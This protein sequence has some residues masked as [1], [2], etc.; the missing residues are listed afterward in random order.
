[1]RLSKIKLAGFKSFVD[2]TTV[3]FPSNLVGVVGPNGCGKSN[4]IDAVRWVMGESSAKHLRG[5][6]M[7]DVIF[8]GSTAR[9][10]VGQASVELIFDNADGTLSGEYAHYNEISTKR[11]VNRDGASVYYLNG[12]RCRRRDITDIFLGTGLGPRSYAIIEQGMISRLIEA[13]PEDMRV[14]LEEAA[15]ISRYKERRRETENRIRHTRDNL[16]RLNDLRE[17]VDKHLEHLARQKRT[18]ERY[19]EFKTAERKAHAELLA[20]RWR[21]MAAEHDERQRALAARQTRLEEVVAEQRKAESDLETGREEHHTATEAFNEVQGRYYRVGAEISATEQQI[22]Y[23][24]ES[25][26]RQRDELAQVEREHGETS[27]HIRSDRERLEQ[28]DQALAED[29]PQHEQLKAVQDESTAALAA[30]EQAMQQW[31]TEWDDFNRRAAEPAQAAQVQRSR[32]EQLERHVEQARQRLQRVEEERGQLETAEVEREIEALVQAEQQASSETLRLQGVLDANGQSLEQARASQADARRRLDEA[33]SE[34]QQVAGRVASLDALQQA[35][36]GQSDEQVVEWLRGQGIA[37]RPRLAQE[38]RVESGWERAAEVVLGPFLEAVCVDD[39]DPVAGA[40]ESLAAGGLG[41]VDRRADASGPEPGNAGRPSMLERVAA[42]T[43]L[44]SLLAGVHT[45]DSVDAALAMRGALRPGE[46]VVTAGGLWIGPNWLRVARPDAGDE[47]VLGRE[48]ELAAA[49]EELERAHARIAELE[50]E[51]ENAAERIRALETER[52]ET[53]QALNRAHREHADL[54]SKLEGRRMRLEQISHRREKLD[55]EARELGEQIEREGAELEAARDARNRALEQTEAFDAERGALQQRREYLA[56][57]LERARE[58]ASS[59][60]DEGHRVELRVESTKSSRDATAQN[61]ERM[62]ARLQQ[63]EQRRRD[64]QA[65]LDGSDEPIRELEAEL[66]AKLEQRVAI[67]AEMAEARQRVESIEQRLRTLEQ[68]RAASERRAGEIRGELEDERMAAQE[69]RVRRQTVEEQLAE[70]EEQAE[71]LLEALPEDATTQAW[72]DHVEELGRKI[73]RLGAVNLAAIDEHEEE[74]QRKEYLD[75]QHGDV[76]Q[77]LET[78]E[79]AIAKIDRDTRARFKQ[80]FDTVNQQ[81]QSLF[82]RLFGGGHAHLEMTGEDLLSTGVSIL[83]R[84]PGKRVANIHLL[85]G[86]EKALTAV[87]LVFAFFELNP[88]PFCMLDE[89]DAPLDDA[90]VGR[91]CELVREMS[92][93]VQFIFITHNK[94]TMELTNQLHGVTMREA[95]ASRMVAVDVQEAAEL[96]EA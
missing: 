49:R 44:A 23:S 58:R 84:P 4:I 25:Q 52:E 89:V 29:R 30:A 56:G 34:Q 28:L 20:L 95:G 64:L 75:R 74:T 19:K 60:R 73:E 6:S 80:T 69:I 27:E 47:G 9:K 48:Q 43:P 16:D 62:E 41:L 31:Q 76:S 68:T 96:A 53:Q 86:G 2:P 13:R 8:N 91:Y 87:A 82:P 35:A 45:A 51:V 63:L 70:I 55:E 83:A 36:L 10:P 92:E 24:K 93:R 79:N 72:H 3:Q 42:D 33:R 81:L 39:V 94:Q 65:G 78:L 11:V 66:N 71:P 32:M 61:L 5:G 67:E 21:D 18:A 7:E 59:D 14:Y 26:Q 85:S 90:N 46:S 57:E 37:E 88:A 17:E 50:A 40:L 12:T 77:A 15:G 1:M 22:Q 38:L 54:G